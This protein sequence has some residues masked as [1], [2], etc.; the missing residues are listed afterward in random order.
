M[1]HE[2]NL[3]I[4]IDAEVVWPSPRGCQI[5]I[6]SRIKVC[7]VVHRIDNN[8]FFREQKIISQEKVHG[9]LDKKL[10][11]VG[12]VTV[13]CQFKKDCLSDQFDFVSLLVTKMSDRVDKW[14]LSNVQ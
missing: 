1:K 12:L 3:E 8:G 6:N 7:P 14:C 5:Q 10:G 13:E 4:N 2:H 11:M 9:F